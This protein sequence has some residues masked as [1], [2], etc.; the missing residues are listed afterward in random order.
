M[1]FDS[2][3]AS[4]SATRG[5]QTFVVSGNGLPEQVCAFAAALEKSERLMIVENGRLSPATGDKISF[6]FGIATFQ[7]GGGR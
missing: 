3:K 1:T 2:A 7:R 6:E 4:P 5:K